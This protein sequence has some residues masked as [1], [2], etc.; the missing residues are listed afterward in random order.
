LWTYNKT[1]N[2]LP[3][4]TNVMDANIIMSRDIFEECFAKADKTLTPHQRRAVAADTF[5]IYLLKHI[6][7]YDTDECVAYLDADVMLLRPLPDVPKNSHVIFTCNP[8]KRTGSMASKRRETADVATIHHPPKTDSE[9]FAKMDGNDH[10]SNSILLMRTDSDEAKKLV[11]NLLCEESSVQHYNEGMY[12]LNA[13]RKHLNLKH[14]L[15][16]A[17]VHPLPWFSVG[18][19]LKPESSKGF[20]TFGARTPSA[21]SI[22]EN[23]YAFEIYGSKWKKEGLENWRDWPASSMMHTLLTHVMQLIEE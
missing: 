7:S 14:V 21:Q 6:L 2:G 18:R 16:F 4:D 12:R 1:L 19:L 22:L 10:F 15:P 13:E 17:C 3:A 23:A 5:R 9:C 11:S 8:A 20:T